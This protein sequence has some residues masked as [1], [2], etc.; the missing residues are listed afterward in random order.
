MH[1]LPAY[2]D[3]IE[4]EAALLISLYRVGGQANV[5]L[6]IRPNAL[7]LRPALNFLINSAKEIIHTFSDALTF[8]WIPLN[9]SEGD[10]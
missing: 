6:K 3:L 5:W 1:A 4:P 7:L 9:R 8:Q 10:L 2:K